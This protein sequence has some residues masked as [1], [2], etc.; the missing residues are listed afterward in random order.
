MT[1]MLKGLRNLA[2]NG[3]VDVHTAAYRV[4]G[5][6]IGGTFRGVQTLLLDHVGRRSGRKRT[7][8]LLYI[9]DGD[10]LVIVASRG[11]SHK[12]PAWWLN[13]RDSPRTTV[14]VDSER[15]EVIA[16]EADDEERARLWPRLVEAW[17]DYDEYQQRT[18]RRIPVILLS[19]AGA[20]G[21]GA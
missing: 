7:N 16:H 6:R 10:D 13:L 19:P 11:G 5:G 1:S 14:Q 2:W 17:P 12:H 15:R 21:P 8:P 18:E 20:A 9:A 3:F 4:T